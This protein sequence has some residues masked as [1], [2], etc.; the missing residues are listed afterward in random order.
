MARNFDQRAT[1]STISAKQTLHNMQSASL[2]TVV[3]RRLGGPSPRCFFFGPAAVG[4]TTATVTA[5]TTRDATHTPCSTGQQPH[6]PG[7]AAPNTSSED[8]P[9][10]G[11]DV[12][13]PSAEGSEPSTTT[14]H[15]SEEHTIDAT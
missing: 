2:R 3:T 13:P 7:G 12:T 5:N 11:D 15:T 8:G 10:T 1:P 14:A 6:I 4:V 9:V